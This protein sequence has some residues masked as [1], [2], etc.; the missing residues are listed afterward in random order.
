MR[1]RFYFRL[2]FLFCALLASTGCNP[3]QPSPGPEPAEK[4][5]SELPGHQRMVKLLA[6]YAEIAR[7]ENRYYGDSLARNYGEQL[8]QLPDSSPLESRWKLYRLAGVAELRAGNEEK[9][10]KLLEAAVGLLPR[11]GSR[12]GRDYAAET[13]FRLGVGHMRRGETL[14]CC[15]RFTP[16]SC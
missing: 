13:I 6:R 12:I 3:P 14:N 16:E 2:A 7:R 9:G 10:I 4:E 11:V 15:A 5:D 1:L 8:K